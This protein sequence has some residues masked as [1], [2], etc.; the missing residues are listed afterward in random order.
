MNDARIVAAARRLIAAEDDVAAVEAAWSDAPVLL[1]H[2][3][4][5]PSAGAPADLTQEDI[6]AL[7]VR[8]SAADAVLVAA[9]A[10]LRA[11]VNR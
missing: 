9:R 6:D 10:D 7:T 8:Q 1:F 3:V 4:K 5:A 11:E 2:G